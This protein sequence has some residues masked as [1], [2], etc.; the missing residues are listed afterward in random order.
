MA[1]RRLGFSIS[2]ALN[3]GCANVNGLLTNDTVRESVKSLQGEPTVTAFVSSAWQLKR[4]VIA[5]AIAN[6]RVLGWT[7]VALGMAACGRAPQGSEH[8]A[9]EV[10]S[11]F[12]RAVL[13]RDLDSA[14][15]FVSRSAPGRIAGGADR[16]SLAALAAV[17]ELDSTML[18][19]ATSRVIEVAATDSHA[20]VLLEIAA[21]S[22]IDVASTTSRANDR[23]LRHVT[24]HLVREPDR[25]AVLWA[26]AS[27]DPLFADATVD[28]GTPPL[29]S[30][31]WPTRSELSRMPV[32]ADVSSDSSTEVLSSAGRGQAAAQ[33]TYVFGV[34]RPIVAAPRIRVRIAS[35]VAA[36]LEGANFVLLSS[37]GSATSIIAKIVLPEQRLA[38]VRID[39]DR[40]PPGVEVSARGISEVQSHGFV[41]DSGLGAESWWT[42]SALGDTVLV[43]LSMPSGFEGEL[44]LRFSDFVLRDDVERAPGGTDATCKTNANTKKSLVTDLVATIQPAVGMLAF[45]H[46]VNGI[47]VWRICTITRIRSLNPAEAALLLTANHCFVSSGDGGL[48]TRPATQADVGAAEVIWD[49]RSTSCDPTG[50]AYWSD[51]AL[52]MLPRTTALTLR[53]ASH[54]S[55]VA[56]LS[57]NVIPGPRPVLGW[58]RGMLHVDDAFSHRVSQPSGRTQSYK[59]DLADHLDNNGMRYCGSLLPRD[60]FYYSAFS[61]TDL[62]SVQPGSSGSAL[63]NQRGR[64]FGQ[65]YGHCFIV[66][67]GRK[68]EYLAD[69]RIDASWGVIGS[70]LREP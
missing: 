13:S 67:N 6:I 4:T 26:G 31:G 51:G 5:I 20:D 11:E 53:A 68:F 66:S 23:V 70:F 44:D 47:H 65:L 43:R 15:A 38:R 37:T 52:V 29:P 25:W 8:A 45:V 57:G 27:D 24:I 34:G 33:L 58:Q 69:G 50:T 3:C 40:L 42:P 32:Y 16:P 22:V 18:G 60:R 28:V 62:L 48:P 1:L 61:K 19:S 10:A 64:I 59:H 56:L 55:D 7:S 21:R 49:Y 2:P 14:L 17:L 9:S 54:L 46:T 30:R 39:A 63:V 36:V 41:V 35:G 12:A